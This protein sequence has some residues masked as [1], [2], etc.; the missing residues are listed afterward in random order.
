M[1]FQTDEDVL[2]YENHYL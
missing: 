2:C 1:T